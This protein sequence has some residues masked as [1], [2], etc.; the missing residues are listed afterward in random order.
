MSNEPEDFELNVEQL[1]RAFESEIREGIDEAA[2]LVMC[3][4]GSETGTDALI[5]LK[6]Y[7][8]EHAQIYWHWV[9]EKFPEQ[10][11]YWNAGLEKAVGSTTPESD[12]SE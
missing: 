3:F 6:K 11:H 4:P 1:A 2:V 8:K 12:D 5:R 7:A 9:S 10:K